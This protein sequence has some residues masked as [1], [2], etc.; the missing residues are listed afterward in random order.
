M[1]LGSFIEKRLQG[2]K[3]QK[4]A[5]QAHR[6]RQSDLPPD[7]YRERKV[8]KQGR[9]AYWKGKEKGEADRQR[10]RGYEEATRDNSLTGKLGRAGKT[11]NAVNDFMGFDVGVGGSGKGAKGGAFDFDLTGGPGL[12]MDFSG[13]RGGGAAKPKAK[14]TRVQSGGKTITIKEDSVDGEQV[15]RKSKAFDPWEDVPG[16]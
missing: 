15:R 14:V 16:W 10:R 12:G 5:E 13:G 4:V 9:E 3:D 7:Y 1:G 8:E 11:V 6:E 2:Y